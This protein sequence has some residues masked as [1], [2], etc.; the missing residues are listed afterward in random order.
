MR[1]KPKRI[2]ID[3]MQSLAHLSHPALIT[4]VLLTISCLMVALNRGRI[5]WRRT[6]WPVL[7]GLSLATPLLVA[8]NA[9]AGSL[10]GA[11]ALDTWR[12]SFEGMLTRREILGLLAT[13][14]CML[15]YLCATEWL[16]W[17]ITQ[18]TTAESQR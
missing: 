4:L 14:A 18:A 2:A 6:V 12:V 5:Q 9:P 3:E 1:R 11:G 10:V 13:A 15:I 7:G 17:R 16:I 8:L